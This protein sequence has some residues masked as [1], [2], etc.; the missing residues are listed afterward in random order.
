L[1]SS[2]LPEACEV[3]PSYAGIASKACL[4]ILEIAKVQTSRYWVVGW[5][6][7]HRPGSTVRYSKRVWVL[8]SQPIMHSSGRNSSC[9]AQSKQYFDYVDKV[10]LHGFYETIS[11]R[12]VVG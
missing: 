4:G 7:Y 8:R 5:P 3:Y 1:I 6:L 12:V 9:A 11:L 10:F 2:F